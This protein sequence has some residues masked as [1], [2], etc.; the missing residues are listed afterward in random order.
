MLQKLR[1]Q[2]RRGSCPTRVVKYQKAQR[3]LRGLLITDALWSKT[4]LQGLICTF[5]QPDLARLHL[6]ALAECPTCH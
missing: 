6:S 5:A 1:P 3:K 4:M 2:A